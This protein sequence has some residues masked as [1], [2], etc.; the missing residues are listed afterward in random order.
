MR[1]YGSQGEAKNPPMGMT[2]SDSYANLGT[3][4]S[5]EPGSGQALPHMMLTPMDELDD[6]PVAARDTAVGKSVTPLGSAGVKHW[7]RWVIIAIVA[8]TGLGAGVALRGL[9]TENPSANALKS[10]I[11]ASGSPAPTPATTTG[12]ASPD[13]GIATPIASTSPGSPA[14]TSDTLLN[15]HKYAEAPRSELA[16][17]N[18]SGDILMRKA[19]ATAFLDL[20]GA[21]AAEGVSIVPLSGFRTIAEQRQLYFD[22]KAERGQTAQERAAWSAPPGYSEH[23]T[24]Y[25]IDIGDANVPALNLNPDFES[26][27]ASRWMVKNAA[28]FSFELS[29]TK[30]NKQGVSY[31]PWHWRYVGDQ[32]S[33]ETFYKVRK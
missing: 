15:H 27:A 33:L 8:G 6:I 5:M 30:G 9:Q 25:T 4:P 26:S 19:A 23:H 12:P 32:N 10:P 29:F 20:V 13:P 11:A 3:L 2:I 16:A 14:D 17:V 22:V 7:W 31:E 1:T 28:K 24:G 18:D 21:A